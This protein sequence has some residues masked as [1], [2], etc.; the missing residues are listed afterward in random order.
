MAN[1]LS[2]IRALV[3]YPFVTNARALCTIAMF[4]AHA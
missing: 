1:T 4:M 2:E 3:R